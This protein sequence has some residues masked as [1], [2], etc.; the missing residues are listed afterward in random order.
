MSHLSEPT[1]RGHLMTPAVTTTLP[2]PLAARVMRR[3]G[4]DSVVVLERGRA[5][6]VLTELDLLRT[7]TLEGRGAADADVA[8]VCCRCL[9]HLMTPD[10]LVVHERT[11]VAEA[12]TLMVE[13][14][15]GAAV[16]MG[17]GGVTGV[18]TGRD[19]AAAAGEGRDPHATRVEDVYVE[20]DP[21]SIHD[22]IER[23]VSVVAA[24]QGGPV[25]VVDD[26]QPVGTVQIAMATTGGRLA[27]ASAAPLPPE[28]E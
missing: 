2:V 3:L 4:V 11:T 16:A 15:A 21:L 22:D 7:A 5:Y 25:P 26:G 23:T 24:H 20:V 9:S 27:M 28:E 18:V 13:A 1:P 10:P 19:V 8:D 17:H 6:G 14:G 12:A